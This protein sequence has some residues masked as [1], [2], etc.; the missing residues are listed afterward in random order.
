MTELTNDEIIKALECC[1]ADPCERYVLLKR[2][3][4]ARKVVFQDILDLIN[5]QK[6]DIEKKRQ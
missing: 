6:A 1:I 5:R 2:G 3:L 4:T